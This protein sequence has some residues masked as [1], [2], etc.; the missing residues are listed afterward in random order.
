MVAWRRGT[1]RPDPQA[2]TTTYAVA[3][4]E[5][6]RS[7]DHQRD[8]LKAIRDRSI[9]VLGIASISASVAASLRQPVHGQSTVTAWLVLAALC[10]MTLIVITLV[11]AWP[12][13]VAFN[14]R[15]AMLVK[16]AEKGKDR[17][18]IERSLAIF[19]DDQ[20]QRNRVTLDRMVWGLRIDI[21]LLALQLVFLGIDLWS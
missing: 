2:A 3:L 6:R 14:Q 4:E 19:M 9:A 20:Y 5:A 8:D 7:L 16:W 12:R 21:A 1:R 13:T 18:T 11:I 17:P 10:L 15:G